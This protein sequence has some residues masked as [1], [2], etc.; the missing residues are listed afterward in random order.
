MAS[1]S[2]E[3]WLQRGQPGGFDVYKVRVSTHQHTQQLSRLAV[4][5]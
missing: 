4:V 5:D 2:P 3:Q 1:S